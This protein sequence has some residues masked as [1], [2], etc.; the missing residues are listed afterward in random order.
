MKYMYAI[1][2]LCIVLFVCILLY[3]VSYNRNSYNTVKEVVD[4]GELGLMASALDD[5]LF[6]AVKATA[7]E[8]ECF[9]ERD[10]SVVAIA[11]RVATVLDSARAM[12]DMI[13]RLRSE[14]Q[15]TIENYHNAD[16][17]FHSDW[18]SISGNNLIP[19]GNFEVLNVKFNGND[20]IYSITNGYQNIKIKS[21][22]P[23]NEGDSVSGSL[24]FRDYVY[25]DGDDLYETLSDTM[26]FI[27]SEA[28]LKDR[29]RDNASI[30]VKYRS[31]VDSV[32]N[33][34]E[35]LD[36]RQY[37]MLYKAIR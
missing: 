29:I 5:K 20:N 23:L 8:G 34:V 11:S 3:Y 28:G 16:S 21:L 15:E 14:N 31:V 17:S 25:Y 6:K 4:K 24:F 36:S 13:G 1:S 37:E 22:I 26:I 27:G 19:F 35:M 12:R 30:T 7:S 2:A 9:C 32:E 10:S 33:I 18:R